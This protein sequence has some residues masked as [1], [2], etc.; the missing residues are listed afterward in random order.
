MLYIFSFIVLP[1]YL[2]LALLAYGS[3]AFR[4]QVR[5][6]CYLCSPVL[7]FQK[8]WSP[9]AK[10]GTGSWAALAIGMCHLVSQH[11]LLLRL[12]G[13][14]PWSTIPNPSLGYLK[15]RMKC[16]LLSSK[17]C[18]FVNFI[19]CTKLYIAKTTAGRVAGNS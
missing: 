3:Q 18:W 12:L 11:F 16:L 17:G 7:L 10:S 15:D 4:K 14:A 8:K 1:E 6:Q 5:L 2:N 13:C 9:L 19:Q